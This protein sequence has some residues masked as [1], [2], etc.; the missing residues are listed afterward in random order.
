MVRLSVYLCVLLP[1]LTSGRPAGSGELPRG[2]AAQLGKG[3]RG[4][5]GMCQWC[6][7]LSGEHHQPGRSGGMQWVSQTRTAVDTIPASQGIGSCVAVRP[8]IQMQ[9]WQPARDAGASGAGPA[10][11]CGM[12]HDVAE[13][14]WGVM[15]CCVVLRPE[16]RD[17][18]VVS[19]RDHAGRQ[20]RLFPNSVWTRCE[21]EQV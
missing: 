4:C 12:C 7:C 10:R 16:G 8:G 19:V 15:S 11:R 13:S 3:W 9:M 20:G 5:E 18:W 6:V 2:E 17:G 14:G 1:T 21:R